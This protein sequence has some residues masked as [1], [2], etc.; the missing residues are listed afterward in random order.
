VCVRRE[1]HQV[2]LHYARLAHL[3]ACLP[4]Q[5]R[6]HKRRGVAGPLICRTCYPATLRP[7]C[8]DGLRVLDATPV[9]RGAS[10]Q[11]VK[12]SGLAGWANYGYSA[13]HSRWSWGL[14]LYM[15]ATPEGMPMA[16]CRTDSKIGERGLPPRCWPTPVAAGAL[17]DLMI[18]TA[19]KGL[20]GCRLEGY[21][22]GQIKCTA[23]YSTGSRCWSM[24]V[25][26]DSC[27]RRR[28]VECLPVKTSER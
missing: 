13:S 16:W 24:A 14:R 28:V 18:V 26:C 6:Y 22:A 21:T 19:D 3:F 4:K 15:L 25:R 20:A 7:S 8:G 9:A 17:R 10:R 11:M 23:G 5:P 1:H 12:R 2:L 27:E